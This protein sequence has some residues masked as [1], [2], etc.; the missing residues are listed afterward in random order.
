MWQNF[1]DV[2]ITQ[3]GGVADTCWYANTSDVTFSQLLILALMPMW[4]IITG[5]V[6]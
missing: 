1:D 2:W 5:V 3:E 6:N 4:A